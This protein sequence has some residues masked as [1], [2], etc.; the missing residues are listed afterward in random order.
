MGFY[1]GGSISTPF[2]PGCLLVAHSVVRSVVVPTQINPQ[3]IASY[4][5]CTSG[6]AFEFQVRSFGCSILHL[7]LTVRF[8]LIRTT[9]HRGPTTRLKCQIWSMFT[10]FTFIRCRML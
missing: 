1:V 10:R 4:L 6:F 3:N 8:S 5:D 7:A 9:A 2:E